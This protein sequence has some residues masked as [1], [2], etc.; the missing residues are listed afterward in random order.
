MNTEAQIQA[1]SQYR[2]EQASDALRAARTLIDAALPRDAINRAYYAIFY[3]VLALLVTRRLGSS[4]HSGVL[5]LLNKE[6]VKT[7]LLPPDRARLARRAFEQRLEADYAELIACS[8]EEAEDLFVQAKAFV[9]NVR[10]LLPRLMPGM[11]PEHHDQ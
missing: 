4:K 5:T 9:E 11:D 6:F 7:G 2:M 10:A 8:R 3:S 1:L